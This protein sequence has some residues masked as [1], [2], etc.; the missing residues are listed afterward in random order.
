M[1]HR[2]AFVTGASSGI[3]RAVAIHL[4]SLG[5]EVALGAR[6]EDALTALA[7]EIIARGGKA[8]SYALDVSDPEAT[9]RV[10][11]RADDQ[12]DG[13]DVVIANAGMSDSKWSGRLTWADC[14]P[15]LAVN[16]T[17]AV[18]TIVALM[19]RMIE[20]KRGHLVGVSSLAGYRGLPKMAAYSA[21]KAFLSTF[22][23]SVRVDLRGTGVHV[24]DVRPGFVRTPMNAGSDRKL[25]FLMEADAAA[26][27][28]VQGIRRAEDVVEFPWQLASITRSARFLPNAVWD[29][30]AGRTR[31]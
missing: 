2:T 12:M 22:L 3:G 14:A 19:E 7:T 21:S 30:A 27:R 6:R 16:V 8:R 28:I 20:R 31:G 9:T 1:E 17:G 23:E 15:T 10:L 18:A 11:K 25:P 4:A 24:T 26:D 13:V 29:R 5:V